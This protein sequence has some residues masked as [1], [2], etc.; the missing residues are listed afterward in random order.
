MTAF[1]PRLR[2]AALSLLCLLPSALASQQ[3]AAGA[4]P[5]LGTPHAAPAP[6]QSRRVAGRVMLVSA[7][8]DHPLANEWVVLH[9]V[10]AD[11][12]APLD[13]VRTDAAGRY[14]F[15]Y[16]TSGDAKAVYFASCSRG[17][18]AYFSSPFT[19][20]VAEGDDA[21][22]SIF[23]TTSAPVPIRVRARHLVVG[24][25]TPEN[26]RPIIEVF[27][28][29][30]DSSVTRVALGDTVPV[31]ESVLLDGAR[32]P[33]L[34][35]AD[36]SERAVRLDNGRARILAPFAPGLKQIS[37][38]YTIDNASD[39][40]VPVTAD[41][42]VLEVL[43]EDPLGRATGA[44]LVSAGPTNVGGRTFARF[45]AQDARAG[46]VVRVS[47]PTQRGVGASQLRLFAIVAAVG[48]ALLIGVA[49]VAMRRGARRGAAAPTA[50]ELRARLSELDA[51]FAAN[52]SPT[53]EQ[54][55][56]HWQAR[57]HL[58]QQI[59]DAVAR[60]QHKA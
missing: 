59:T 35:Q 4:P 17:G 60:E 16:V 28:L 49:R 40:S 25:P 14:A 11:R 57:A 26:R 21:L 31:W 45:L 53:E 52:T 56:D 23:D 54:R 9:R 48:A 58:A 33:T 55:A 27:E 30:N 18:V 10:G 1:P 37:W 39:F 13:S 36:F 22:L 47:A 44:G 6:G 29:S 24:A 8:G 20:A 43:I 12:A 5:V 32:E 38:N 19:G 34:A 2:A 42:P 50:E 15:K 41:A 7:R 46:A 51:K 3:S